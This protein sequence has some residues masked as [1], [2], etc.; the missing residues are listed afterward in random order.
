MDFAPKQCYSGIEPE[1][2]WMAFL[3]FYLQCEVNLK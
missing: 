1:F 3:P 2:L